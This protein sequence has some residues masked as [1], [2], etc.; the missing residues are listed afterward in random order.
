VAELDKERKEKLTIT[1]GTAIPGLLLLSKKAQAQAPSGGGTGITPTPPSPPPPPP[2][3]PP[4]PPAPTVTLTADKTVLT[5][6]D[7]AGLTI[8]VSGPPPN[9]TGAQYWVKYANTNAIVDSCFGF[10]PLSQLSY[11]LTIAQVIPELVYYDSTVNNYLISLPIGT[12]DI[13]ACFGDPNPICSSPIT[14]TRNAN[15]YLRNA[16]LVSASRQDDGTIEVVVDIDADPGTYNLVAL[17]YDYPGYPGCSADSGPAKTFLA[18]GGGTFTFYGP[19]PYEVYM[20]VQTVHLIV[21]HPG[22]KSITTN[23]VSV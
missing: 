22:D 20:K 4:A 21:N 11:P 9:M 19:K 7:R 16:S 1:L 5:E 23:S 14:I 12:Y 2:P 6:D 10:I 17:C 8:V 18:K 13:V 3:P 15:G